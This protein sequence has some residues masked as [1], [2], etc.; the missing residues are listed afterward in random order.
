MGTFFFWGGF[1]WCVFVFGFFFFC[2]PWAGSRKYFQ[3][4][5]GATGLSCGRQEQR[6]PSLQRSPGRAGLSVAPKAQASSLHMRA[7]GLGCL[8]TLG[9]LFL[10]GMGKDLLLASSD[11]GCCNC[12][13]GKGVRDFPTSLGQIMSWK[14]SPE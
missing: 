10:Y 12:N 1:F 13:C 14:C 9:T 5:Y 8:Q 4:R 2:S 7:A 3:V 11:A 6:S